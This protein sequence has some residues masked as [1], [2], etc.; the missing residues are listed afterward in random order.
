MSKF[1]VLVGKH[2]E[3]LGIVEGEVKTRSYSAGEV[4]S[5]NR[6]LDEIHNKPGAMKFERLHEEPRPSQAVQEPSG[7]PATAAASPAAVAQTFSLEQLERMSV[8]DLQKLAEEEE[9]DLK[10]ASKKQ[11]LIRIIREAF[12]KA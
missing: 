6:P 10:G 2:V 9:I 8:P 11:D 3:Q 12:S 7:T 4:V 1:R 5:S